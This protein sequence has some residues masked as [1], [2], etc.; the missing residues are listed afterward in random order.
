MLE[1]P[2]HVC[3]ETIDVNEDSCPHCGVPRH[4][5]RLRESPR[6]ARRL[7]PLFCLLGGI[8]AGLLLGTLAWQAVP[9]EVMSRL[10]FLACVF[11]GIGAAIFAAC[12]AP[13]R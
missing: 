5:R 13:R 8:L 7:V 1:Q 10:V 6:A 3:G 2:C 11:G 12:R 9:D 4:G